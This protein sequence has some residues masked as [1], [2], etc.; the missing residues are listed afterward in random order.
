MRYPHLAYDHLI[1]ARE[2]N[3]LSRW[4]KLDKNRTNENETEK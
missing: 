3:T 4:K 1:E 2:L